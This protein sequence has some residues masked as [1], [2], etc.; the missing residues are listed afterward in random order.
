MST[1]SNR[2][3]QFQE[4]LPIAHH[5]DTPYRKL[6]GDGVSA[7]TAGKHSFLEVD[8]SLLTLL[9]RE[10]I[11]DISHLLRAGHLAQLRK[12]LDDPEASANDRFVALDLLKNASIAAGIVLP[13]CQ[14]TG[15]AIIK[16]KKGQFVVTGGRRRRPRS[17]EGSSRRIAT[18]TCATRRW[19]RSTCG[20][21]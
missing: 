9:A 10:A 14:D 13:G 2:E 18:A 21:R 12:I 16:G 17:P 19:R 5:D 20:T 15:T 6:T 11:R 1:S 7:F 8:T 3:F 4:L